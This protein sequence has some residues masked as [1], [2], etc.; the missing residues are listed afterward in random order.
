MISLLLIP[1]FACVALVFIHVHFG[2]KVLS[3]GIL[4][5]DLAIA[6]WAGLG[7]LL[8]HFWGIQSEVAL[9][10][11]S[12]GFTL[13]PALILTAVK[14]IRSQ[15]NYLEA[16]I[17]V[18]YI[19]AAAIATV[20]VSVTGMEF[21]HMENM[22]VGH[23]LFITPQEL[24][25]AATIYLAVGIIHFLARRWLAHSDNWRSDLL[26]Y[27]TFGLVVT[28][29]VKLAGVLAVF[30]FLVLPPLVVSLFSQSPRQQT[31]WGWALGIMASGV[32]LA[33]AVYSDIPPAVSVILVLCTFWIFSIVL[34]GTRNFLNLH[35]KDSEK[36]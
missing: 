1:F 24:L 25:L 34:W 5:I 31:G 4:F 18:L 22:L 12:F 8:G 27:V 32:G 20:V 7:Y 15:T 6:Q 23:L 2:V 19:L 28:S 13:I 33:I 10:T 9:Y 14:S 30:S 35:S 29:S 21:H 3:R 17:G 16:V 11:T 26:F 36:P